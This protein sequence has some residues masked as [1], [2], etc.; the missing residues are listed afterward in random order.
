MIRHTVFENY[1]LDSPL[2]TINPAVKMI[3]SV[4]VMLFVSVVF[5]LQ[6]LS[7]LTA[8]GALMVLGLG[9]VRPL[10]LARALLP[11]LLFG[12]GFLWMNALLPRSAGTTLFTVGP[13]AI[14][15]EGLRNG[16][17]FFLRALT[18]GVWSVLFVASTEPTRFVLSL[19]HQLSVPPKIAYSALA[20]YRYLPSLQIEL[21]QI[22]GAHRLRG[23]GEAGGLRGKIQRVYRYT[24]P[25]LAGALRRAGRVAAAMEA[26]GFS[27]MNRTWY[28]KESLRLR[29]AAY[30]I[31]VLSVTS[32]IIWW[33]LYS[34]TLMLW[35]GRLWE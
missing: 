28:R 14:S 3:C 6:T 20:A 17:S 19:V 23:V 21:E 34:E 27:G 10:V 8:F 30:A 12:V 32:L 13:V 7:L 2:A 11:F 16:V 24:V 31:G 18:F 1:E 22:R 25:L 4:I 9:R 35:S 26:R 5:D 29:D 15:A 33:G